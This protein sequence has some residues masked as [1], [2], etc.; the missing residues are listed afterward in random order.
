[1]LFKGPAWALARFS[2]NIA[3]FY[4][5]SAISIEAQSLPPALAKKLPKYP[6]PAALIGRLAIDS[7][8]QGTGLGGFLLA[9]AL[10]RVIRASDAIAIYAVIVDAKNET[11]KKFYEKYGFQPF[12]Q[13]PQ[14]LFI[15]LATIQNGIEDS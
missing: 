9:D 4:T 11:A 1:M 2:N 12:P 8:H 7:R 6:I 13:S 15:P 3:G 14:R 10:N 5:L